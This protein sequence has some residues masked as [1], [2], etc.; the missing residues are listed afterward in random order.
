[1]RTETYAN[2]NGEDDFVEQNRSAEEIV[3]DSIWTSNGVMV[4]A[5]MEELVKLSTPQDV[6]T[7]FKVLIQDEYKEK[8]WERPSNYMLENR[9]DRI[10]R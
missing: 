7:H 4:D 1:M 10:R 6:E 9:E 8:C 3:G 5:I 2:T